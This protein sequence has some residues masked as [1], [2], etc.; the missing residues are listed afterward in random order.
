MSLPSNVINNPVAAIENLAV[1]GVDVAGEMAESSL[2]FLDRAVDSTTQMANKAS[3][4]YHPTNVQSR[5]EANPQKYLRDGLDGAKYAIGT[6][7]VVSY[8]A[9]K[10]MP[11]TLSDHAVPLGLAGGAVLASYLSGHK[12]ASTVNPYVNVAMHDAP[13]WVEKHVLTNITNVVGAKG[14]DATVLK[15]LITVFAG[16]PLVVRLGKLI[17]NRKN[18]AEKAKNKQ[19]KRESFPK[20]PRTQLLRVLTGGGT[21]TN[22]LDHIKGKKAKGQKLSV[23]FGLSATQLAL[24]ENHLGSQSFEGTDFNTTIAALKDQKS[25]GLDIGARFNEDLMV[26]VKGQ[27]DTVLPAKEK[28]EITASLQESKALLQISNS[29]LDKKLMLADKELKPAQRTMSVAFT[30]TGGGTETTNLVSMPKNFMRSVKN[31]SDLIASLKRGVT[32]RAKTS[33]ASDSTDMRADSYEL[34]LEKGKIVF[35]KNGT[36]QGTVTQIT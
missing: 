6:V 27:D 1:K 21:V 31:K 29:L 26:F 18:K 8:L 35:L 7:G 11:Q 36:L 9:D 25:T 22:F 17:F 4:H 24:L 34:Q 32:F 13:R 20:K 23:L 10:S 14:F 19:T 30:A 5:I 12:A 15:G 2:N 3:V 16:F 28:T 33:S